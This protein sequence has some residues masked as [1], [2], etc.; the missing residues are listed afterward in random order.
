MY[1]CENMENG[2]GVKGKIWGMGYLLIWG[3]E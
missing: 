3:M 1:G 2:E